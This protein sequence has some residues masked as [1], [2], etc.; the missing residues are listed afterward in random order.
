MSESESAQTSEW[1]RLWDKEGNTKGSF[2]T[3]LS[4][5]KGSAASTVFEDPFAIIERVYTEVLF[6]ERIWSWPELLPLVSGLQGSSNPRET[7]LAVRHVM[8]Q[9]QCFTQDAIQRYSEGVDDID[10]TY[11]EVQN[12]QSVGSDKKDECPLL[13]N[14][15]LLLLELWFTLLVS[16]PF[17][18]FAA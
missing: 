18:K 2:V 3:S 8:E 7:L 13:E 14:N 11:D 1:L 10:D 4:A 16:T 12:K 9:H 6:S 15:S 5:L 17:M